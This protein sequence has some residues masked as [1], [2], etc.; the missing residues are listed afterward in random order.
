MEKQ[1]KIHLP[2]NMGKKDRNRLIE[3]ALLKGF[4]S[5]SAE[6]P[7]VSRTEGEEVPVSFLQYDLGLTKTKAPKEYVSATKSAKKIPDLDWRKEKGL[8]SVF[9]KGEFLKD[10]NLD[11]LPDSLDMKIILPENADESMII[12]ACN[13][14][15]RFGME[16]TGYEG[17]IVAD[18]SYIGN[19]FMIEESE[20]CEVRLE[21]QEQRTVVYVTG[22][23]E[24]LER[25]S[26]WICEKFPLLP[27]AER[28]TD[29][30]MELTDSFAMKNLDGQLSYLKAF[31]E[32]LG[33]SVTAYVSPEIIPV[34]K[35]VQKEFPNVTFENYK[36]M[37]KVYEK[38][39]DIPWEVDVCKK[40]LAS[41]AYPLI[42]LGDQVEVYAALSEEADVRARLEK[43]IKEQIEVKG[44][45]LSHTEILCAYKQGFSWIDEIII[46]K[47]LKEKVGKIRI[48]FKPFLPDGQTDWLD[49]NGATPS[50]A[51]IDSDN[52]DKWYDLPIRYLQEL[53]PIV[54]IIEEK[55]EMDKENI[56]FSVY[57]GEKDCTYCLEAE[58]EEGNIILET[59]YL[60][61]NT[62]RS[63]LD[64]YPEMGKVHPATGYV[65][66]FI[67]GKEVL[68]ERV[69]TD[70]ECIWDI[71]QK[72]VL[73]D[74]QKFIEGK[75]GEN[76]CLETQPF[77]S[78]LSL[79]VI[80]SEPDYK[81]PCREDLI[82]TLDALH[83]DMYFVGTDFFKNYGIRHSGEMLDA[84]GLI[85]P[86]LKKGDGKPYFKVTLYDIMAEKPALISTKKEITSF[87]TRQQLHIYMNALTYESN[88]VTAYI[89]VDGGNTKVAEAYATLFNKGILSSCKGYAGVDVVKLDVNGQIFD[90]HIPKYEESMKELDIREIDLLEH[91]LIGYEQYLEII[92]QLKKVSGISVYKTA[93]S[94]AGRD[95][96][97][98]EIL[99][100][101]DGYVSSTKRINLLPSEIINSRH[102][103]NEV[104]STNSAF[105]LLKELLT[106][107]KYEDLS[108]KMNLI[109]VPMENV[110][111]TAIHYELQKDNPYWKFHVARFNAIG[112]EFYHEH[113]KEDTIHTEAMGLTRL[114]YRALPDIIVDNHGVPSHEW[115]QQFSGY[116]SP[117]FKGF[118]LPRSL[119]Y[120]YFWYVTNEEYKS[121]YLVN[122]K[123]EDVIADA[124]GSQED[125]YKW[126]K[127][128]MQQFEKFAHGWMPKLFPANYY[129]DMINYWIPF[130]YQSEHRYPSIRFPWITTVAYTS[131][132]AD[133]TAQD[134]Y[135]HLCA[136]AHVIHDLAT[137]DMFIEG[138]SIFETSEE[139]TE[140]FVSISC[141]RQRPLIVDSFENK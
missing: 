56:L 120:G 63:Y 110:D 41:K 85:L 13:I 76:I 31:Q 118:W 103:A 67:N 132:V 33:D 107:P 93:T 6:F 133:E 7:V 68:N 61:T 82:S 47:L 129:K 54:D 139:K 21:K 14:A 89:H 124:I 136:K 17:P 111:G 137:I 92:E 37:K 39:Y 112:K 114:W 18:E 70:V 50:Y 12:A 96:Y 11:M 99:P 105:M 138:K 108:E 66:V 52:P 65:K 58:D 78:R 94:Y 55:L 4:Q 80:A 43:E 15:F 10:R 127:E 20:K 27:N 46:P 3:F 42:K 26:S 141:I 130:E 72:E 88:T 100:N 117:S 122:K 86:M 128:W 16:T 140:D 49:E 5:V 113:F 79:E 71:Y 102:H 106:N 135:L 34:E 62:E 109:I 25:F 104:S 23:G 121:N 90:M 64:A 59:D 101:C 28:W 134:E 77:F 125:I 81:L 91:T 36:G 95:I 74:L 38:E 116:T 1:K 115:E 84:P 97:A 73:T 60:A 44:A 24:D 19:V 22:K 29:R 32:E 8:E 119:L 131:E 69:R 126:N 98:I 30:L 123:M 35:E 75:L 53:Y 57:E 45:K 48:A 51:N 9:E 87:A 2:E 83:E 40:I